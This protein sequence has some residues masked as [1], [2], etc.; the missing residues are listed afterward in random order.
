MI[1][2]KHQLEKKAKRQRKIKYTFLLKNIL[3][4]EIDT[5]YGI[6]VE[7]NFQKEPKN[8]TKIDNLSI[9]SEKQVTF[10]YLDESKKQHT[11]TLSMIDLLGKK[12]PTKTNINCYWC[13]HQFSSHPISCP[14]KYVP[15]EM[16]K[17]YFSEITRDNYIIRENITKKKL[18]RLQNT[19]FPNCKLD[20]NNNDF[21]MTD[22][23]F[24]SFNCCLSFINENKTK[25]SIYYFFLLFTCS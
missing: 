1:V 25:N 17:T 7:H 21:Y 14:I 19:T 16:I 12:I 10:S 24:C 6:L 8:I 22:G 5:L 4:D 13:R 2:K 18:K 9:I 23:I 20:I 15:S 3:P 11:Y